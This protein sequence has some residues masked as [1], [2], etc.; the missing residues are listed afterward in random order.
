LAVESTRRVIGSNQDMNT[1]EVNFYI[2]ND[3]FVM[4]PEHLSIQC[5]YVVIDKLYWAEFP[6]IHPTEYI[7]NNV[8]AYY[9]CYDSVP[10]RQELSTYYDIYFAQASGMHQYNFAD[11]AATDGGYRSNSLL[12]A[13]TGNKEDKKYLKFKINIVAHNKEEKIAD[14]YCCYKQMHELIW[15][16]KGE[17]KNAYAGRVT[18]NE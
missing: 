18:N 1:E 17:I 15:E 4:C 5:E 12:Y 6:L 11:S 2:L 9:P 14:V 8:N 7:Q 3:S 16:T 13:F 10:L